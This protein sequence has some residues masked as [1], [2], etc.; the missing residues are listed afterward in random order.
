MSKTF[1][2]GAKGLIVR[3]DHVLI[4]DD[5]GFLDLPG[6][7]IDGQE[8]AIEALTRELEEELPG[9]ENVHIG[10]L[11]G[12]HR[13]VDY[14]DGGHGLFLVV[15]QVKALA[16]QPIVLSDE[17]DRAEWVP[18]TEAKRILGRMALDWSAVARSVV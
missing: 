8:N 10:P 2:V 6:G 4:L 1:Y 13:P 5:D 14:E 11:L 17:H 7:R 3:D 16:P 18:L 12:W 9:I 15:F